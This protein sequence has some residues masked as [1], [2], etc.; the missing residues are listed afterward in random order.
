MHIR[1]TRVVK[2]LLIAFLAVFVIQH[3]GDQ[4]FGA[5]FV[6]WLGLVP[7]G[8]VNEHRFWQ[9]FTYPFLHGDV[10]HLV[11]NLMM[12][13]SVGGELE[14]TWGSAR[15]LRF[16]FVCT[17]SA[18]IFFLLL[19]LMVWKDFSLQS[20][21][22][23]ASG[24][25]YGLLMAYGLI[26]GERVLLFMMLFPMKAKHFVWVLAGIEFLSSVFSGRGGLASAA[27]LG[28]MVAGFAYL[29]SRARLLVARQ[30]WSDYRVQSQKAQK[31]RKAK[32]LKLVIDNRNEPDSENDDFDN[33]PKTWH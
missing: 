12:M 20:P 26:F 23:G 31:R 5:N 11:L 24:G 32:H 4:F 8:I 28:G 16:F 33:T 15:F 10:M 21:M 27:H 3:T 29:W 7:A 14:S 17:V 1:L 18:G 30:Q 22:I 9:L 6:G 2:I 25:I 19:Q 13:V